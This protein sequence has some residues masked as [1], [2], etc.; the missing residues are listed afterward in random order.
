MTTRREEILDVKDFKLGNYKILSKNGTI[1]E[2]IEPL[3]EGGSGIVYLAE[4]YFTDTAKVKR[5]I[6]FFIFRDDLKDKLDTYISSDNFQDEIVNITLFNHEN[7][8]KVIDGG[9]HKINGHEIPFI[10]T[11]FVEG[12]TLEELFDSPDDLKLYFKKKERVIDLF[13]QIIKGLSYIHKR[14][15]YHCDIA[16]KN[17]FIKLFDDDFHVVIGDLGV[18]KSISKTNKK[19]K[20]TG[21]RDYMPN[22]V[23]AVKDTEVS[24]KK[25]KELQPL[26][27]IHSLIITFNETIEKVFNIELGQK[28]EYAWLNAL[29]SLLKRKYNSINDL[30]A[31]IEKIQPFHRKTAGLTELSE[32]D[33][34][35]WKKLV[36]IKDVLLTYRMKRIFN[37]P[38]LLRLKKV[39]QLLMG[40]E[41]FPGSNHTRYEHSLGT[42]ENMRYILTQLLKKSKFIELFN[43]NLLEHALL[44]AALA[45]ITRFPYSFAIH[46][47]KTTDIEKYKK[48]NQRNLLDKILNYSEDNE[49]F[50]LSLADVIEQHFDF[51]SLD[52]LKDIIGGVEKGFEHAEIQFI[53]SLVN[54]SIDVRVLDFLKRDPYHLGLN[55]GIQ[56]DF[57]SLIDF[58]E[59]YNNKIAISS[60]GVSYVEQ[61]IA[62]RY[63]MYKN[64]YWNQPNR[65]YTV[66]LK[67]ILIDLESDD[68][69]D[70]LLHNMLF[71]TPTKMLDFFATKAVGNTKTVD[72]INLINSNRPRIFKRLFVVNK[73]EEESV[74]TGV[75]NKISS[76]TSTQ[77]EK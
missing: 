67:Q 57:E 62:T 43:Q 31:N 71:A 42:Y 7:L 52:L 15:F 61:V 53:Y 58:L 21:T 2:L 32:S 22:E 45:N 64:I 27:D 73:S 75:C 17:I 56:F 3:G 1:E 26:W 38:M 23:Q 40:S 13:L 39:P 10:I 41:I 20:I 47:I 5:A 50:K 28:T 19:Y 76:M 9:I 59:I 35:S 6:K 18:G 4:Q 54:S 51:E 72:L 70:D 55:N 60:R 77:I 34:G 68:F 69:Q 66:M 37:H 65:A 74:L 36:P 46:E 14:N 25:F 11:D 63:W 8:I 44:A 49:Y 16:P 29:M 12:K 30:Q 33:S 24:N 48:I